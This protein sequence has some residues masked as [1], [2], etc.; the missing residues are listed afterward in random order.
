MK[1]V[2][3]LGGSGTLGR[4]VV[5]GLLRDGHRVACTYLTNSRVPEGAISAQLDLN[6]PAQTAAVVKDLAAKLDGLDA[7]VCCA[8]KTS[9]CEPARFDAI[10]EVTLDGWD[11]LMRVNVQSV[12]VAVRALLPSLSR[13]ANILFFG[14]VDGLKP[15]PSPVPY[16]VSKAALAGMVLSLAKALGERGICV[17]MV[18]PGVLESGASRTL[19]ENLRAEYLKHSGLRRVGRVAEVAELAAWMAVEN[20]YVTGQVLSVDGGL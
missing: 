13:G 20:T 17:N 16:A 3:V 1:R 19:P 8:V 6:D 12:F 2:L 4:E 11:A 15:V 7:L 18:A 14:S 9:T 10:D 5:A